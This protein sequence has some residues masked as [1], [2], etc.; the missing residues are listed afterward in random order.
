MNLKPSVLHIID[1]LNHGGAEKVTITLANLF[2]KKG[3]KVGILYFFDT[4]QNI[5]QELNSEI[6]IFKFN[7]GWKYNLLKKIGFE[8]LTKQYDLIHVHMKHNLRYVWFLS[9]F[10]TK[11]PK[12]FF[13]DHG[14]SN[15]N[16]FDLMITRAA[17]S[18]AIYIGVNDDLCETASQ[19]FRVKAPYL[20]SNT[21]YQVSPKKK[22]RRQ[23]SKFRL[24][25]VSN[26]HQRKNILFALKY[27]FYLIKKDESCE[28]DIIGKIRDKKYYQKCKNF[29]KSKGLTRKIKFIHDQKN[30]QELLSDYDMG[31]HFSGLE[32]GPIVLIEYFAQG[33]PFLSY[34]T[35]QVYIDSNALFPDFFINSYKIEKW[36]KRTM[37]IRTQISS[38]LSCDMKDYFQ[39]QFSI[40]KYY[41][42][43]LSIYQKN[44]V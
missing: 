14:F 1:S 2:F 33:L 36:V 29:C 26:I 5:I 21:I 38:K 10:S 20:L 35:G 39:N 22:N 25:L 42:T 34:R 28:L 23:N 37:K 41:K 3:H 44:L 24:V 32:T 6:K 11:T 9:L 31:L 15:L 13:H 19:N 40:K 12:I 43:C 4:K 8:K 18:K 30:A 27:F 17:V 7:R 16:Y